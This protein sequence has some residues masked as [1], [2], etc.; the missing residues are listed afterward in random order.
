MANIKIYIPTFV[1]DQNFNPARVNPRLF[2]YNGK[3]DCEP[4][5]I[6]SNQGGTISQTEIPA[7]PYFDHYSVEP[8]GTLPGSNS[9]SL[10]FLNENTVYGTPPTSSLYDEYWEKYVSLLY[11]PKT[12]LLDASAI[13]ALA[14]YNDMELND[15]V[16]FRGNYYHLRA[17]NEYDVK[18]GTCKIQLLGPILADSLDIPSP[19][20]CDFDFTA[21]NYNQVDYLIVAGGGGG[22]YQHA[23][24]G[25]AG[26]LISGSLNVDALTNY[27][28][29]VGDGGIGASGVSGSGTNGGT[30]SL[31]DLTAI[32]GGGGGGIGEPDGN[33]GGSG[34]GAYGNNGVIGGTSTINQGNDGADGLDYAGAGGGGAS[35]EG[36]IG[37][38]N[39]SNPQFS[40]GGAGGSGSQWLD[41]N[42]YAGGG[43]G[44]AYASTPDGA[45]GSI[46]G[47]GGIGGGG[48]GGTAFTGSG[49]IDGFDGTPNT[50]GGGGGSARRGSTNGIGGD[51]GSGIV[52]IR[53]EGPQTATGGAVSESGGYTYHTFT[54]NGT[55]TPGA[56]QPTTTTTTST[57]L[58][59]TTTTT[60]STTSS[61][62]YTWYLTTSGYATANLACNG[63]AVSTVVY[64]DGIYNDVLDFSDGFT[65][66]YTDSALT[67]AFDGNGDYW[68]ISDIN[69][70]QPLVWGAIVGAGFLNSHGDCV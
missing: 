55:F 43:G 63:G 19:I 16:Q 57:T 9:N 48:E 41:G 62:F 28:V 18:T 31:F 58:T 49:Q 21:T 2:F 12:R 17:I 22:G 37:G 60:T 20:I 66:F 44:G 7:F 70:G 39:F 10:L 67:T 61:G 34:G 29:I 52:I 11:D 13:I 45:P 4:F 25:G 26:G 36:I 35:Q 65:R 23:G 59:P 14:D 33:T 32:G 47:D 42:F 51:G 69:G 68:G 53:Y 27:T 6:E 46:G 24:G 15:I 50:G 1:S 40:F 38:N 64:T 5:L 56:I 54:T 8:G 30:S 3:V